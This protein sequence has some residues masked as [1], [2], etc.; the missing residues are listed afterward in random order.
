MNNLGY[1]LALDSQ[2][3]CVS[4][5]GA[6]DNAESMEDL[7]GLNAGK[8]F[9]DEEVEEFITRFEKDELFPDEEMTISLR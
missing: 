1:L 6:G 3:K 5:G 4:H 7:G 2:Q 8:I 9:D